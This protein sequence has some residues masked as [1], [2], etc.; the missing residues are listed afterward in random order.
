MSEHRKKIAIVEDGYVYVDFMLSP[1]KNP[2][3]ARINKTA[4]NIGQLLLNIGSHQVKIN[5]PPETF[6]LIT[7]FSNKRKLLNFLKNRLG[8]E[9]L[10]H[11]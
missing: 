11:I 8:R 2:N 1:M 5:V 6:R 7:P 9:V 3:E 10:S 4:S